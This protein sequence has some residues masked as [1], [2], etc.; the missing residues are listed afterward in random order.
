M[1]LAAPLIGSAL[2]VALAIAFTFRWDVTAPDTAN[3]LSVIRLD[4]WTGS[5]ELCT[6]QNYRPE[7]VGGAVG[8]YGCE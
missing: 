3:A 5:I 2:I 6:I 4:R 7:N 1:R 8:E